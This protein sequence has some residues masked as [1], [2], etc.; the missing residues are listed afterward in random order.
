[1]RAGRPEKEGSKGSGLHL[2][3]P[4]AGL[5]PRGGYQAG[6][7]RQAPPGVRPVHQRPQLAGVGAQAIHGER[8]AEHLGRRRDRLDGRRQ[9]A[10]HAAVLRRRRVLSMHLGRGAQ[11]GGKAVQEAVGR[12]HLEA[13]GGQRPQAPLEQRTAPVDPGD[14]ERTASMGRGTAAAMQGPEAPHRNTWT[15]TSTK[16]RLALSAVRAFTASPMAFRSA[17][18]RSSGSCPGSC[19]ASEA[20]A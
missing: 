1:M 2:D 16:S 11:V 7:G 5:G 8:P 10:D 14:T 9:L 4:G 18:V 6:A 19:R 17:A 12:Q 13:G 3:L 15:V 20:G